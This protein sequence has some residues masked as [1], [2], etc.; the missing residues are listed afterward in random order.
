MWQR[1][2]RLIPFRY[3]TLVCVALVFFW[4]AALVLL[5]KKSDDEQS[6]PAVREIGSN[7]PV[8]IDRPP[9]ATVQTP[10]ANPVETI[11]KQLADSLANLSA[12]VQGLRDSKDRVGSKL[13][14]VQNVEIGRRIASS[15]E[16]LPLLLALIRFHSESSE[17]IDGIAGRYSALVAEEVGAINES[18]LRKTLSS[19]PQFEDSLARATK[20]FSDIELSIQA[21]ESV[22]KNRPPTSKSVREIIENRE[23]SEKRKIAKESDDRQTAMADERRR[24]IDTIQTEKT[25]ADRQLAAVKVQLQKLK[26]L[27]N[28][29][30]IG[31]TS[32]EDG[33]AAQA[34]ARLEADFQRDLPKIKQYL[35]PLLADGYKQPESAGYQ[36]RSNKPGPVSLTKLQGCGALVNSKTGL[37]RLAFAMTYDNDRPRQNIPQYIGGVMQE[38]QLNHFRPALDLLLKYQFILVEKGMLEE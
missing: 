4:L 33:T 20:E 8:L 38:A 17:K 30:G 15:E 19:L 37:E 11:R 22:C 31:G 29:N 12:K 23:L 3:V 1:L 28:E 5:Q 13:N 14:E 6:T 27:E 10:R 18:E 9:T 25:E 2:I 26:K 16:H 21:L 35:A 32:T 7:S 34:N 36:S 24:Q